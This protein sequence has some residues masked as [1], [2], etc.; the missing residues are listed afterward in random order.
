M[1]RNYTFDYVDFQFIILSFRSYCHT[2]EFVR[3][4]WASVKNEKQSNTGDAENPKKE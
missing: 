4:R 2:I 3:Q 1:N